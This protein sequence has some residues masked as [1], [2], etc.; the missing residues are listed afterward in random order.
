MAK[1]TVQ[2][3]LRYEDPDV[4]DGSMSVEDIVPVPT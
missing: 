4:D 1:Q 3:S 2:I